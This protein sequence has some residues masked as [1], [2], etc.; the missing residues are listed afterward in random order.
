MLAWLTSVLGCALLVYSYDDLLLCSNQGPGERVAVAHV[1]LHPGCSV[2]AKQTHSM[3]T[4]CSFVAL[5][6]RVHSCAGACMPPC[7]WLSACFSISACP[8]EHVSATNSGWSCE[9]WCAVIL[10]S[11]HARNLVQPL[12]LTLCAVVQSGLVRRRRSSTSES[13]TVYVSL[14]HVIRRVQAQALKPL[15]GLGLSRCIMFGV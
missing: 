6:L 14:S 13:D 15:C 9:C 5:W 1:Q 4:C 12:K 10:T 7:W 2:G 11:A 8:L 3:A